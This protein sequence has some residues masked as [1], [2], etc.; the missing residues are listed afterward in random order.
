MKFNKRK[1]VKDTFCL[2]IYLN[3]RKPI[4]KIVYA[5]LLHWRYNVVRFY[6]YF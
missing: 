4:Q 2:F 3:Y 6:I 1:K 5:P